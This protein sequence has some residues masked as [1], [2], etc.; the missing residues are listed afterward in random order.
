VV[1]VHVII[2]STRIRSLMEAMGVFIAKKPCTKI[3]A[4]PVRRRRA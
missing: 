2:V 1:A 3:A 4:L